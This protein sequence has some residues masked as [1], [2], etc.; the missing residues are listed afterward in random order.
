MKNT[1]ERFD[2]LTVERFK[3]GMTS[4][5]IY[6]SYPV[7]EDGKTRYGIRVGGSVYNIKWAYSEDEVVEWAFK[8]WKK[9]MIKELV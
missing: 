9:D 6:K 5:K 2:W 7:M 3:E 8:M 4:I 1:M